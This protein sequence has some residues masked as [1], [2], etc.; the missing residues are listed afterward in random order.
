MRDTHAIAVRQYAA[1]SFRLL[2]TPHYGMVDS[3]S[4]SR[5]LFAVFRFST[6]IARCRHERVVGLAG[7]IAFHQL[8][9]SRRLI[10][11]SADRQFT[12]SR[13]C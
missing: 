5:R 2:R 4:F 1:I 13:W 3:C 6:T 10:I 7:A 8:D 11:S 9:L 12:N